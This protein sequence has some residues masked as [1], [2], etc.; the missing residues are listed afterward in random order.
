M[1]HVSANK[2][3]N[4]AG[5]SFT[6]LD[7]LYVQIPL[8]MPDN[9]LL[10][11]LLIRQVR[12]ESKGSKDPGY[13]ITLA[14]PTVNLGEIVA[15]I[16]LK[17]QSRSLELLTGKTSTATKLR[18]G[19]QDEDVTLPFTNTKITVQKRPLPKLKQL[20]IDLIKQ[21]TNQAVDFR[22]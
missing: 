7:S 18:A 20:Y 13:Q 2:L 10:I 14:V 9:V 15:I 22:I 12:A 4:T 17:G 3:L 21:Q 8:F 16:R 11:E 1:Q 5:R 6:E 19:L